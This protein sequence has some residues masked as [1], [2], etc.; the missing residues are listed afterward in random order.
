VDARVRNIDEEFR[1]LRRQFAAGLVARV[2]RIERAWRGL[3]RGDLAS[4]ELLKRELHNLVGACESYGFSEL[5]QTA[6]TLES[7][8]SDGERQQ[9]GPLL[10]TLHRLVCRACAEAAGA[11]S[12]S[13]PS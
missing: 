8:A 10:P 6:R 7:H 1:H 3:Y 11:L 2:D 4:N 13:R 5:G 12:N 9:I